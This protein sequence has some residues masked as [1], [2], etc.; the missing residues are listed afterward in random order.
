MTIDVILP[1]LDEEAALGWV[2]G[3]MPGGYRPIVVDNG[4]T[5]RSARVARDLGAE[6]VHEPRRGFGA[7]CHAGL[8]AASAET[9]C[10]MDADASLDPAQ[11]PRVTAAVLGGRADLVLGRRVPKAA[12]AW[13]P[14]ARLGNAVLAAQL[15][16]RTGAPLHDLGPMRAA[17]RSA[18][19]ALELTDRRFG[20]PL[21]MVLR[22]AA[23]GW[24]IAEV[25]VDYLAR[26][27]R[28][29]VTGTVRGTLRAVADMRRVIGS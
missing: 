10:F 5:D 13:P 18:L 24:R 11:L 19:L 26:T 2:L 6:V 29:K 27:G 21:E 20:Y 23:A 12:G 28:S 22:A 17:G 1:C 25:E 4:S 7:A 8:L 16:R 3:R 14:H 15:R 9:V